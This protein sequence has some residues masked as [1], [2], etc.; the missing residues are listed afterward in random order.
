MVDW[1]HVC[2]VSLNYQ[3]RLKFKSSKATPCPDFTYLLL[4][5]RILCVFYFI[6]TVFSSCLCLSMNNINW[7]IVYEWLWVKT[8]KMRSKYKIWCA[9]EIVCLAYLLQFQ[10]HNFKW[11]VNCTYIPTSELRYGQ[12]SRMCLQSSR[13]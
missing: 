12:L 5:S 8:N 7:S 10:L 6:V 4:D 1:E 9:L 11:C 3:H 13:F 2:R